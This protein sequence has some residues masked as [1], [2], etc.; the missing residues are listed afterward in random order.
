MVIYNSPVACLKNRSHVMKQQAGA[1]GQITY[2]LVL[3]TVIL[4]MTGFETKASRHGN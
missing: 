1:V 2:K 3:T 4:C